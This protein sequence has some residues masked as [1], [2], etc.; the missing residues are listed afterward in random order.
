MKTR[1]MKISCNGKIIAKKVMIPETRR[2][3]A[4][5]MYGIRP[6]PG[7]AMLWMYP[8]EG[9]RIF[10]MMWIKQ[11]LGYI[12]LDKNKKITAVGVAKPWFT[13]KLLKS[14]YFIETLP[15]SVEGLQIGDVVQWQKIK[16]IGL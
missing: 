4:K 8:G 5:G 13:F 12:A 16:N 2:E 15:E 1:D 11:K 7:K 10:D 3:E 14:Q 6:E 9:Y